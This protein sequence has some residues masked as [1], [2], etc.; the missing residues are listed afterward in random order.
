[1]AKKKLEHIVEKL[2]LIKVEMNYS[3]K[4]KKYIYSLVV[5]DLPED[6]I[7][8]SDF[9]IKDVVGSKFEYNYDKNSNEISDFMFV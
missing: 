9:E 1:M 6:L 8:E 3:N 5:S 7:I 2:T 4:S